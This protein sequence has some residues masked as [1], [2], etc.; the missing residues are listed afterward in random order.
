MSRILY[1]D[2]GFSPRWFLLLSSIFRF[3]RNGLHLHRGFLHAAGAASETECYRVVDLRRNV[4]LDVTVLLAH[5]QRIHYV[6][7]L[8]F[9]VILEQLGARLKK[10]FEKNRR[11]SSFGDLSFILLVSPFVSQMIFKLTNLS[12]VQLCHRFSRV[13]L[14]FI[15]AK[16]LFYKIQSILKILI[17]PEKETKNLFPFW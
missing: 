1:L 16:H 4:E 13:V 8:F 10:T 14:V 2:R 11:L 3:G 9:V 17:L 7:I 6:E 12:V 15:A 5:T